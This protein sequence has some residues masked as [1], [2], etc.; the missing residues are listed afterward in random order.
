MEKL[1]LPGCCTLPTTVPGTTLCERV[2]LGVGMSRYPGVQVWPEGFGSWLKNYLV[3][4]KTELRFYQYKFLGR[5]Y[6]ELLPAI[7]PWLSIYKNNLSEI[8]RQVKAD[9]GC[10]IIAQQIMPFD[11]VTLNYL[12]NDS[13]DQARA[14]LAIG[15]PLWPELLRQIDLYEAQVALAKKYQVPYV[16]LLS[17]NDF[18]NRTFF[19]D[20]VHL[21][22]KGNQ[23]VA[24]HIEENLS[25]VC[26]FIN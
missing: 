16:R 26:S 18:D 2:G 12:K 5:Q 13:F 8:I 1:K 17:K 23:F 20:A 24:K 14:S 10:F 25:E 6:F 22:D 3:F 15:Q 19:I 7:N 21:T 9:N 4:K 11:Q